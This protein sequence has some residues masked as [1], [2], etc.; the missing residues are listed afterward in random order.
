MTGSKCCYVAFVCS[1]CCYVRVYVRSAVMFVCM[2]EVLLCSCAFSK[3][4]LC[5]CVYLKCCYVRVY[6]RSAVM[7]VCTS[8]CVEAYCSVP[9]LESD[10]L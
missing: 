1:K 9:R 8:V 2:F 4:C 5:S 6:V 7:F 3:C 10:L